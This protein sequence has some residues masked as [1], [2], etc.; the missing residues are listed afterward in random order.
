[1]MMTYKD[2]SETLQRLLKEKRQILKDMVITCTDEQQM[3]FKRMYS[4]KNLDLPMP[5]VVDNIPEEK[6]DWAIIQCE[7]TLRKKQEKD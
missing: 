6:L 4:H 7:N 2:K 1:M 3:L 5:D